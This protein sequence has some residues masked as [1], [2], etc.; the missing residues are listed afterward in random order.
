[1]LNIGDKLEYFELTLF[2]GSTLTLAEL[3]DKSCLLFITCDDECEHF[4]QYTERIRDL[5]NNFYEDNVGF[6]LLYNPKI[7][8]SNIGKH[9]SNYP[10]CKIIN[11]TNWVFAKKLGAS[12]IPEVFLFNSKR[13]LV[14]KGRID[15]AW[16]QPNLVTRVYLEDAI[17]FTLDGL[18]VDYP[19]TIPEGCLL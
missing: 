4:I 1:M 6:Q 3:A 8:S 12:S 13:E 9:F 10:E 11:D 14:Y 18:E 19:Q 17:E 5:I 2:D 16:D 15:D 7:D